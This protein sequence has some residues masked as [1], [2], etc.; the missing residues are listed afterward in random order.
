[1]R[2]LG[3][4]AVWTWLSV[5]AISGGL[6]LAGAPENLEGPTLVSLTATH[7]VTASN[8]LALLMLSLGMA[9]LG[10]GIL[11]FTDTWTTAT[12]TRKGL[13]GFLLLQLAAGGLLFLRSGPSTTL[14]WWAPGVFLSVSALAGIALLVTRAEQESTK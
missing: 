4:V 9:G 2:P 3:I 14:R 6:V 10:L 8:V 13:M 11:L 5:A 7:G 12:Q 1:V